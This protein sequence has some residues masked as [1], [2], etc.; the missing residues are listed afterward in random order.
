[1]FEKEAEEILNTHCDCELL[2]ECTA[3]IKCRCSDFEESKKLLIEGIEFGYNKAA[4]EW[5]YPSKGE[6]P[7]DEKEVL[8]YM[9]GSLYIGFYSERY[10]ENNRWHFEQFSE[11]SEQVTAWKEIV[12]PKERE[13]K[14]TAITGRKTAIWLK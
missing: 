1:M 14:S 11:E 5:H 7:K 8:V 3:E 10:Y 12:L 9:W 2:P 13:L 4:N 6:Y